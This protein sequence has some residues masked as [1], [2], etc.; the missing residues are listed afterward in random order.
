MDADFLLQT[1]TNVVRQ[2]AAVVAVNKTL[3]AKLKEVA[4]ECGRLK[5]ENG[6][7]KAE[8]A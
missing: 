3:E 7:L 6:R 2:M 4:D 1:V 8:K 5:E